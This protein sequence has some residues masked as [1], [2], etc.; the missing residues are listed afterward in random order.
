MTSHNNS[1]MVQDANK[2]GIVKNQEIMVGPERRNSGLVQNV[3]I[4][5]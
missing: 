4:L 1:G 3:K 5:E 2:S